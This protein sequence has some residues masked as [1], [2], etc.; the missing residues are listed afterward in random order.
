[1]ELNKIYNES[2]LDTLKTLPNESVN[3]IVTSPPYNKGY[4]SSNRNPNNGF[5]TKSRRIDYGDFSDNLEPNVYND[6][7]MNVISECLRVLKSDGSM[8]YNHQPIQKNHQEV[9]PLF[10]YEFPLKQTILWDRKSTPKLDKSYFYPTIE[11]VFWLQ[12]END[13]RVKFYRQRSIYNK[14]I[15]SI[16]PDRSNNFPAP[17]PLELVSNCILSC[18]DEGDVVYDPFMGSGTTAVAA[19]ELKRNYIGSEIS[20]EYVN[21]ANRRIAEMPQ[22]L[23]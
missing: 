19:K 11:Y 8:F 13:S 2:C 5:N 3:L 6:W 17:F 10:V 23:F 20:E 18:T 15:W 4:W 12:K 14:S 1:M 16:N 22:T 21:L 7:Q 9:N